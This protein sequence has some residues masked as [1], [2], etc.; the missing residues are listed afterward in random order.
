MD[1]WHCKLNWVTVLTV[2]VPW[3]RTHERIIHSHHPRLSVN[4]WFS[5]LM[6]QT[7]WLSQARGHSQNGSHLHSWCD[8]W[9]WTNR[10]KKLF[11]YLAFLFFCCL[12]PGILAFQWWADVLQVYWFALARYLIAHVVI[13][14]CVCFIWPEANT[15]RK[16]AFRMFS[17]YQC[18]ALSSCCKLSDFPPFL[19]CP[20]HSSLS[21]LLPSPWFM[22]V[23]LCVSVCARVV[24][25]W[26]CVCVSMLSAPSP[27]AESKVC[28]EPSHSTIRA[29]LP[30]THLHHC[31]ESRPGHILPW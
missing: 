10:R 7:L 4:L 2:C 17:F 30:Y 15:R 29:W 19:S 16:K 28:G 12:L 24:S 25:F 31:Q 11:I 9:H 1:S 5:H 26:V 8:F 22:C 20:C 23:S 3:P 14:S 18:A 21:F 6:S 13:Y 27:S